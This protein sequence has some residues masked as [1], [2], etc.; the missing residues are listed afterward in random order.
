MLIET[1]LEFIYYFIACLT[2]ALEVVDTKDFLD[3]FKNKGN[4][5]ERK[6]LY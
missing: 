1:E 6:N 2:F 5:N 3:N 4:K